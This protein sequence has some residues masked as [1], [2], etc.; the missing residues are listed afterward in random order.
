MLSEALH[1]PFGDWHESSKALEA[2]LT[3]ALKKQTICDVSPGTFLSV[4]ADS[5]LATAP[6]EA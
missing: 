4:C 3:T 2:A 1:Q 5:S 6:L